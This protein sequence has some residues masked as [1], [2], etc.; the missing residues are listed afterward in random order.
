LESAANSNII[1]DE[2]TNLEI[3]EDP[4]ELVYDF[5]VPGNDSFMVDDSIFVHNTLNTFHLSGVAAK[6]GMTRGVP[7][8]KELL[9][10]TQNPKATSLTIYLRPDIRKSKEDARRLAQ[11][12]EFTM[13]RDL[14]TVSRIY[15]DPR[16]SATLI[17]EDQEWLSFF[18]SFES[19]QKPENL[20]PW[21]IRLEMDREKMFNKN[22]TMD[23]ISFILRR[24]QNQNQ[25]NFTYT[26]HNST[27]MVFRIRLVT[28]EETKS[29][30]PPLD[31]LTIVKHN[32]NKLLTQ[33]LV[34]GLPG[35]KSVS[36]R[37]L[38]DEIF[39]KNPDNDNK[40]ESS[41]QF[42]LDTLGTNF[43]DVLI[44]PDVDGSRLIS[45]HV[46]D[47]LE[48]L[49][50]EAARQILFREIFG[51]FEQAAPVNYRHVALLCDAMCNRGRMMSA[52]RYGVNKKKSGPLAKASFEQT[53][54][55]MLNAAMFGEM[56]PMTGVSANIMAGQ[57][58][59]GGTSF[60][61]VLLD[62]EALKEL[63]QS[64]PVDSETGAGEAPEMDLDTVLD[65]NDDSSIAGCKKND[66]QIMVA[67]PPSSD[68]AHVHVTDLPDFDIRIVD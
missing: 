66:L 10:V 21:I 20:S 7:R 11:E 47:I 27:Q 24:S 26:D 17:A 4:Q 54:L 61:Q 3:T 52:D 36:Y 38:K 34:R 40:Y 59:R 55:I 53:E 30:P 44:H 68:S 13:L 32:Q 18:A 23:D 35:L 57:P 46:H 56:D 48:N 22:I 1:W 5:T 51:L 19:T 63:I 28:P 67:L 60:C 9:K 16:D 62:E 50:I 43:L 15:Y 65:R 31:D 6:S 14:V 64:T 37:M 49:G 2:I 29:N 45:N 8:L 41:D 58:I 12:L 25:I 42:V 39:E 33:T